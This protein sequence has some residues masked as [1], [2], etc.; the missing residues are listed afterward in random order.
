MSKAFTLIELLVTTT[1]IVLIALFSF[2]NYRVGQEDLNLRISASKLS[3]NLRR[4]QSMSVSAK[5]F[6]G[7]VPRGGYGVYFNMASPASYIL[8]ADTDSGR[9]YDGAG[10]LVETIAFEKNTVLQA[11][12][13]SGPLTIVFTPPDPTVYFT[14]DSSA[15]SI[16]IRVTGQKTVSVNKA[17]LIAIQ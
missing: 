15:V 16:T 13:P 6:Q 9:D 17:G 3:Q 7:G 10:E 1:I 4:A 14:P 11:L 8:F 2:P 12:S 5:E